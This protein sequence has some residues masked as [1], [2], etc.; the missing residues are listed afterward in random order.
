MQEHKVLEI[1]N[2]VNIAKRAA[3]MELLEKDFGSRK[4]INKEKGTLRIK[5]RKAT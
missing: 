5:K 2:K 1:M 4:R 3:H